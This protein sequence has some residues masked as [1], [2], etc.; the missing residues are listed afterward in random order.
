MS[1]KDCNIAKFEFHLVSTD[2]R[3]DFDSKLFSP[4]F[5]IYLTNDLV[6]VI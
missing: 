5:F 4:D 2:W 1:N 6:A 3:I